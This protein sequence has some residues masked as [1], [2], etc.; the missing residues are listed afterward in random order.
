MQKLITLFILLLNGCTVIQEQPIIT[1]VD[2]NY[3]RPLVTALADSQIQASQ[4]NQLMQGVYGPNSVS[5]AI[6]QYQNA[7]RQLSYLIQS[8][9]EFLVVN[10]TFTKLP[11]Y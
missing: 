1:P 8:P 6:N 9:F 5:E 7:N 3:A 11:S 10:K 2:P 4:L